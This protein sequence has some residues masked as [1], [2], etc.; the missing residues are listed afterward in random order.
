MKNRIKA[1]DEVVVISGSR[2]GQR[3]KVLQ[4]LPTVGRVLVEGINKIKKHQKKQTDRD[5]P[6]GAIIEREAPIHI[7]NVMQAE[8]YDARRAAARGEDAE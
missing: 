2:K 6:E 7:S 3:G 8:R 4:V 1:D 5:N